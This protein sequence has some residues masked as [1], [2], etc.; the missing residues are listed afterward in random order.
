MVTNNFISF[1]STEFNIRYDDITIDTSLKDNAAIVNSVVKVNG[2]EL[3]EV[4]F[5]A[6]YRRLDDYLKD[7]IRTL[8]VDNPIY[9]LY[10]LGL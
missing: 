5:S 8:M 3:F 10:K 7:H 1:I 6:M 2:Y 4:D 9:T